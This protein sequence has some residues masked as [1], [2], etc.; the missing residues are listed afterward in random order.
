MCQ[1]GCEPSRTPCSSD[2]IVDLKIATPTSVG[3]L[4]CTFVCTAVTRLGAYELIAPLAVNLQLYIVSDTEHSSARGDGIRQFVRCMQSKNVLPNFLCMF[5]DLRPD[6]QTNVLEQVETMMPMLRGRAWRQGMLT[7]NSSTQTIYNCVSAQLHDQVHLPQALHALLQ[8]QLHVQ[9]SS[10]CFPS[11]DAADLVLRSVGSGQCTGTPGRN[12]LHVSL[13]HCRPTETVHS[14]SEQCRVHYPGNSTWYCPMDVIVRG[15]DALVKAVASE[16]C[17]LDRPRGRSKAGRYVLSKSQDQV[18]WL[19]EDV[20]LWHEGRDNTLVRLTHPHHHL[21]EASLRGCL[22][23]TVLVSITNP[24]RVE[25]QRFGLIALEMVLGCTLPHLF[26]SL[27]ALSSATTW[28]PSDKYIDPALVALMHMGVFA[29]V[30]CP[31][32]DTLLHGKDKHSKLHRLAYQNYMSRMQL[33]TS[34][35]MWPMKIDHPWYEVYNALAGSQAVKVAQDNLSKA[36]GLH[37]SMVT[38]VLSMLLPH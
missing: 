3:P 33:L 2:D 31:V 4:Y 22:A 14:A 35:R 34:R 8:L 15:H 38:T 37:T 7:F 1:Y 6:V 17:Q 19:P 29:F 25:S 27:T 20:Q 26:S 32:M 36:L 16:M 28:H 21:H 18:H 24:R 23:G 5:N 30:V 12:S 10:Y 13:L 11:L 9:S